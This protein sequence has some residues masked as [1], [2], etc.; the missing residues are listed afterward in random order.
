MTTDV[1]T[2]QTLAVNVIR[3]LA[4]DGPQRA[5]AGHPGTAMACAPIG[6]V[7]YDRV[8]RH[9]PANP[10]WDNRDR[11][12]LSAGHACILQYSLLHLCGYG[13]SRE[14]LMSFRQWGSI[15]PGHPEHFYTRPGAEPQGHHTPGIETT[16]GPLGQGFANGVGMAVAE[17]FLAQHFNR[18]GFPV[19][20]HHVYALCSDGDLMEGVSQEAASLAGHLRLGKLIYFYDDNHITI[21]GDTGLAFSENVDQRFEAY[22]WHVQR[23]DGPNDL[24]ALEAAI[25]RAQAD[26]RP[27]LISVRTHIAWPAP[28]AQDTA[29]AHGAPLGKDEVAATKKIL[30]LPPEEDFYIP[31][32]LAELT[33]RIRQRGARVEQEWRDMFARYEMQYPELAAEYHRW[34][35]RELPA[36]W[37]ADLPVFPADP[38]GMATRESSGK[39]LVALS[40]KLP[41]LVGGSADLAPSTKTLMDSSSFQAETPAGRNLHFGIREHGMTAM[42]NGMVLHGGLFAFGATF[43]IFS[44]Y[45][46]PALRL[47][48]LSRIPILLVLTHDSI[49]L[50]EDGPTHQAVEHLA[51]LRAMINCTVIRPCDANE[52]RE[53]WKAALTHD[54]GPVALVL[55]R[56]AVP[57]LDRAS[58][59]DRAQVASAELLHRG[60]YVLAEAAGGDPQVLLI[61]SGSEVAPC[62]AARDLLQKEGIPTRVVS[63]PCWEF[64]DRQPAEYRASVLPPSVKARVAV[65]A[66]AGL[67]WERYVGERGG[68]VV[69]STYG[70]SAPSRTNMEK[71]GFTPDNVAAEARRVL[72]E[73]AR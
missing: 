8:M 11:F 12:I 14:D 68:M 67:G 43:F 48:A 72:K 32:Q 25:Q 17:R 63:M 65:E 6:W 60:A 53:A 23:L 56:Q 62:L 44:D 39:V 51:A 71:F 49:G 70:A 45:L 7:L 16:T 19:V 40:K 18:D 22:G 46:R 34:M 41:N 4:M 59:P 29:E 36:G 69:M 3:G 26:P 47:A 73:V 66:G 55:S 2:L 5:N 28:H 64:F 13:V 21:E 20:D 10:R 38:K 50:G 30:G 37:D 31:S 27:S 33:E 15:T 57:T 24:D 58:A 54:E 35:N 9:N 61:A 52:A 1:S 42:L